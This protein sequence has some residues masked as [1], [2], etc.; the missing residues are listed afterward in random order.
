MARSKGPG[1]DEQA[2]GQPDPA[3]MGLAREIQADVARVGSSGGDSLALLEAVVSVPR[4]ERLE[5]ARKVFS[6]LPADR[7][8][9]ILAQTF[10]DRDMKEVLEAA[11]EERLV[12]ARKKAAVRR[13]LRPGSGREIDLGVLDPGLVVSVGLFTERDVATALERGQASSSCAR[14]V[15]FLS[16]GDGR[17]RVLADVFNPAGGYFVTRAYDE[18]TWQSERLAAHVLVRIGSVDGNGQ[19]FVPVVYGAG[20]LDFEIDTEPRI[21]RLHVGFVVIDGIDVFLEGDK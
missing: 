20:R 10:D 2:A 16:Q 3:I 15:E 13:L 6:Q 17:M 14:R 5:M 1:E 11:R 12:A 9:G 18:Q 8:W 21:G 19:Q 4:R 7:Q